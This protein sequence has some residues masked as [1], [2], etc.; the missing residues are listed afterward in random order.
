MGREIGKGA[1]GRVFVAR[2]ADI[3]GKIDSQI[4][5][6]KR[7]KSKSTIQS[8]NVLRANRI[9][10][11]SSY[12]TFF[13]FS[14]LKKNLKSNYWYNRVQRLFQPVCLNFYLSQFHRFFMSLCHS[15]KFAPRLQ[16]I[17]IIMIWLCNVV[18]RLFSLSHVTNENQFQF[19]RNVYSGEL[20]LKQ[21]NKFKNPEEVGR[22][23]LIYLVLKKFSTSHLNNF[24]NVRVSRS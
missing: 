2:L 19:E 10:K 24:K 16:R 13:N 9:A 3:P 1:F 17:K 20:L 11:L 4:V 23:D 5:A 14:A 6:I 22:F 15:K 8:I 18:R 12:A 7:L 21:K